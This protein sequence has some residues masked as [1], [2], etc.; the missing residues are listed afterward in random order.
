MNA[1]S[2]RESR[3]AISRHVFMCVRDD[4][5][6]LLD[7]AGDQ[8]LALEAAQTIGLGGM[9]NGWPVKGAASGREVHTSVRDDQALAHDLL[10]RGILTADIASGKDGAP[11]TVAP[12]VA[13]L[14]ADSAGRRTPRPVD[15]IALTG[16]SISAA[17]SLRY[18]PLDRVIRRV[19]HR[20]QR[21]AK[22]PDSINWDMVRRLIGA[23]GYLRP[24]LFSARNQCL[25]ECL[26][27][28]NHF[29][30][31]NFFPTWVF[32]VHTRPFAAHCWIQSDGVVLNDTL[33][34]VNRYT[35]IMAI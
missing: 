6:I 26:V 14:T 29:A 27:L 11:V 5:L 31:Y 4:D 7:I 19:E 35:P 34:H 15:A 3:Y 1:R 2:R 16:S 32:G 12:V 23:Y 33:D 13:E 30:R 17:L 22:Q 28:T 20:K 18:R 10:Q 8:Y 25:F 21:R 24:F 9:V